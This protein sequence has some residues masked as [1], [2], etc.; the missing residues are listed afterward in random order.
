MVPARPPKAA[1]RFWA[2]HTAAAIPRAIISPYRCRRMPP[3]L[4][5]LVEGLGM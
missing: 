2:S 5:P 3:M 1:H 4:I